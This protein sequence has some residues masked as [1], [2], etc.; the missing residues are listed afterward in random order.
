MKRLLLAIVLGAVLLPRDARACSCG[1]G[2][3]RLLTPARHVPAALNA[4]VRVAIATPWYTKPTDHVELRT[5]EGGAVVPVTERRMLLGSLEIVELMPR[6]PL[7]KNTRYALALVR[8]DQ[9]PSTWIFGSFRTG[10]DV[11][12]QAPVLSPLGTVKTGGGFSGSFDMCGTYDVY[13]NVHSVVASDP[14]R[15]DAR[16]LYGVWVADAAGRVDA[17][18]PPPG[19]LELEEG[20]WLAIGNADLCNMLKFPFPPRRNV[21]LGIAAVDEAGNTSALRTVRVR[22]PRT[23]PQP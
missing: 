16:L 23:P 10:A 9:K 6:A 17:S 12:R 22:F 21:V 13:A 11:D 5:V 7:S 1:V 20:N 19:L 14:G 18:K 2:P 4:K 15:S 3:P 8:S